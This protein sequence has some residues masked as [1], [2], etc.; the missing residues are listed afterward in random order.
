MQAQHPLLPAVLRWMSAIQAKGFKPHT[1]NVGNTTVSTQKFGLMTLSA[2][3]SLRQGENPGLWESSVLSSL[4]DCVYVLQPLL[5]SVGSFWFWPKLVSFLTYRAG[6]WHAGV[7]WKTDCD[8]VIKNPIR[9]C[10]C[11]KV[12]INWY[13][14]LHFGHFR[15]SDQVTR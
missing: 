2:L 1:R 4:S 8:N 13:R 11:K 9:I 10:M 3:Q 7:L 5:C 12:S 15:C 14:M 6:L